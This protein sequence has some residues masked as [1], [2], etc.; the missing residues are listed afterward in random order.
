MLTDDR[1]KHYK[2]DGLSRLN[3]FKALSQIFSDYLEEWIDKIVYYT[4]RTESTKKYSFPINLWEKI[5][6]TNSQ[7]KANNEVPFGR[8]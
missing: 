6:I 8:K 4:I 3:G 1:T 5:N 2:D 7:R